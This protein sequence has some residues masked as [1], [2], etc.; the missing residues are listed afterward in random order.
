MLTLSDTRMLG[1][2][3]SGAGLEPALDDASVERF[4]AYDVDGLLRSA[5][6]A[7]YLD[8]LHSGPL[9][10]VPVTDVA[11]R[12]TVS[13]AGGDGVWRISLTPDIA[14]IVELTFADVGPVPLIDAD[15]DAARRLAE[16]FDNPFVRQSTTP[17]VILRNGERALT[18]WC[19]KQPDVASLR[20]VV[21]PEDDTYILDER[22]LGQIP[23]KART[24][25][26]ALNY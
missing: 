14:R 9:D 16:A 10:M 26:N 1:L 7:W 19:A 20:A 22:A 12:V 2:W 6:R 18:L 24:A 17:R 15:S 4:D 11:A 21:V 23:A 13:P 8:L 3:R 5:M 25:I